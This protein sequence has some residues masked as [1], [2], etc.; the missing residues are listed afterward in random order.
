M[1]NYFFQNFLLDELCYNPMSHSLVPKHE[2]VTP[3]EFDRITKDDPI[4]HSLLPLIL[5]KHLHHSSTLLKID[6]DPPCKYLGAQNGDIIR[7]T[8]RNFFEDSPVKESF[9]YRRV[10]E[11]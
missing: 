8:R 6:G 7:V 4:N 10:K 2:I 11:I 9:A 1:P 5:V 3:A